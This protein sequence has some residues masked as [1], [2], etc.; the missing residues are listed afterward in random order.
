MSLRWK[1]L[2]MAAALPY[3]RISSRWAG[4]KCEKRCLALHSQR[5]LL[6]LESCFLFSSCLSTCTSLVISKTQ[7]FSLVLVSGMLWL[8]AWDTSS[9][10]VWTRDS[11]QCPLKHSARTRWISRKTTSPKVSSQHSSWASSSSSSCSSSSPFYYL[12]AS[13]QK[14]PRTLRS[15]QMVLSSESSVYSSSI[16]SEIISTLW[17]S[18][19]NQCKSNV[20]Q[21]SRNTSSAESSASN[22]A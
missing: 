13:F 8:T 21:L 2:S 5:Y 19:Q 15:T 9:L 10:S 18:T 17:A 4:R 3:R 12:S 14:S 6:Q 11:G 20:L 1:S 22:L 7:R 16:S